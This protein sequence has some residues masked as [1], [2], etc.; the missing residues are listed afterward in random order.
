MPACLGLR[1]QNG[2]CLASGAGR[3]EATAD[4]LVVRLDRI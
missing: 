4:A 3:F 2:P 1:D